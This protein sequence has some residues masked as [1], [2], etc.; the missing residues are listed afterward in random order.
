MLYSHMKKAVAIKP[1]YIEAYYSLGDSFMKLEN[2][3][4]RLNAI[5]KL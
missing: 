5:R 1:D 3:K 4:I 2:W